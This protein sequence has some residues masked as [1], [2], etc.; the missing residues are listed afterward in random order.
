MFIYLV[1][2]FIILFIS[3]INPR[4]FNKND[5]FIFGILIIVS[6]LRYD[7]GT[8]YFSYRYYFDQINFGND[9]PAEIGFELI[10]KSLQ[11]FGFGYQSMFLLF[12]LITLV[13]FYLGL[14][15]YSQ[16]IVIFKPTLYILFFIYIY[17]FSFNGVRQS[18]AAA[19]VFLASSYFLKGDNKKSIILILIASLFHISSISFIVIQ[20][21]AN[22]SFNRYK[23]F[24]GLIIAFLIA[25]LNIFNK[26]IETI[27]LN[28][29]FLDYFGYLENYYYST[30]N[31]RIIEFGFISTLH[32]IILIFI[33]FRIHIKEISNIERFSYHMFY[34]YILINILALDAPMFTRMMPYFSIFLVIS[35][36]NFVNI[37]PI[38]KKKIIEIF[39]LIFYLTL[40]IFVMINGVINPNSSDY[41]PYQINLDF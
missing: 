36:S 3:F 37:F 23:L 25:K 5:I 15:W 29:N 26:M 30:Y 19:I 6:G 14:R 39:I 11:Y 38:K 10:V 33:I 31:D 21:I 40:I 2:I 7:V 22:K 16:N 9:T 8:D 12:S 28:F 4:G 27:I 34:I 13:C 41:I 32:L 18:L 24:S 20:F 17:V 1:I 35:V